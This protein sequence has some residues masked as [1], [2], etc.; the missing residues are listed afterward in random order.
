MQGSIGTHLVAQGDQSGRRLATCTV[1]A[2]PP[3][4]PSLV[5]CRTISDVS[6]THSSI[7]YQNLSRRHLQ[8][9]R[10]DKPPAPNPHLQPLHMC[11]DS[12]TFTGTLPTWYL[13]GCA[14]SPLHSNGHSRTRTAPSAL[15]PFQRGI[16]T[17]SMD[18]TTVSITSSRTIVAGQR[19]SRSDGWPIGTL[20][21]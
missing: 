3:N 6:C 20:V 4:P 13:G 8:M 1:T 18:R 11:Q 7:P 9:E 14:F 19:P 21:T 5:L 12:T 2:L 15:D 17:A 10:L 16:L